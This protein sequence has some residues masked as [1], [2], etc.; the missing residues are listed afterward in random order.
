[1]KRLIA[2][3]SRMSESDQFNFSANLIRFE[4]GCQDPM[5]YTIVTSRDQPSL[6]VHAPSNEQLHVE[7]KKRM[8]SNREQ[9]RDRSK[10][11]FDA[12]LQVAGYSQ[13]VAD[14]E[15]CIAVNGKASA[16]IHCQFCNGNHRVSGCVKRKIL[17]E[18]GREYALTTENPSIAD[19]LHRRLESSVPFTS[20][21]IPLSIY[22]AHSH[23]SCATRILCYMKQLLCLVCCIVQLKEWHSD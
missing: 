10:K 4:Q 8:K 23:H 18:K 17:K 2:L 19:D 12:T 9:N 7:T 11:R 3:Y 1:M 14:G 22:I 6:S 21:S 16:K 20:L 15:E 5:L 13:T